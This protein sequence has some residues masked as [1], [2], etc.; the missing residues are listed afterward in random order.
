[1]RMFKRKMQ[2]SITGQGLSP[3]LLPTIWRMQATDLSWYTGY[4]N[5]LVEMC[6]FA[7]YSSSD[8][9][10]TD[11]ALGKQAT[12]SGVYSVTYPSKPTY[13]YYA[14]NVTDGVDT[15]EGDTAIWVSPGDT[16]LSWIQ[17]NIANPTPVHSIKII[18]LSQRLGCMPKSFDIQYSVDG[19]TFTTVASG[20]TPSSSMTEM[21]YTSLLTF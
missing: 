6:T 13:T 2:S 11:L 9:T 21:Y 14:H 16:N 8:C 7:I 20:T 3:I 17:V 15:W 4:G 5:R 1:M 18:W 12:A 10:G 19:V